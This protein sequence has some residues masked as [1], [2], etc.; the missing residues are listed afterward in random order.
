MLSQGIDIK[1]LNTIVLFA[2]PQGRQ[3]IQRIGRVLRKDNENPKK[4]AIIIICGAI[5]KYGIVLC[6]N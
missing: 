2:T 3:F 5:N 4:I 1:N 6:S